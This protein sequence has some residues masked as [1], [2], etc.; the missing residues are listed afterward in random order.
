MTMGWFTRRVPGLPYADREEAGRRLAERFIALGQRE[1]LQARGV[2]LGIPRGGVP[3]AAAVARALGLALDVLVA[4]KLGAPGQPE[5]A[6]GA[7]AA[8]GTV[9]LEPWARELVG[10]D[11]VYLRRAADEEI[12]RAR[13]RER[14]LRRG[15]P[16]VDLRGRTVILVDD[17]I[18]TGATMHVAVLAARA[19]GAAKVIV[20][21]PVGA[22]ESVARLRSVADDVVVLATPEPFFAVGEFYVRFDQV[23]DDEVAALLFAGARPP[24]QAPPSGQGQPRG[25]ERDRTGGEER[26]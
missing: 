13:R 2:V 8:D 6:I 7:V 24:E 16:P 21:S 17:G 22:A 19:A 1:A 9:L 20:A 5:L 14:A 15:R 10:D 26:R 11:E 3:V 18:A 4:H 12:A 25:D 23:D